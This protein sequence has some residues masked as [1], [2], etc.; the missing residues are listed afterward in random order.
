[1]NPETTAAAPRRVPIP[2]GRTV[3]G[4]DHGYPEEAPVHRRRVEAFTMDVAPVTVAQFAAFVDA[5]GHVSTAEIPPDPARHPGVD[6]SL[7][8]AGSLVF[9]PPP[10]PVPL[11]D[12]RRWWSYVP[13]TSWRCPGGPGTTALADHPVVHVSHRDASAYAR[14]AGAALPTEAQWEHAARAGGSS[15]YAWGEELEPGGVRLA[16]TWQGRF[17]WEDTDPDGYRRTSPVG[18]YPA[19]PWGLH[20]MIGNVW[21]WTD[22]PAS[23]THAGA[24]RPGPSCCAPGGSGPVVKVIKGGSHL[25]S[26]DYCRRYRPA[27]RQFEETESSTS[28]LGFRCVVPAGGE[29]SAAYDEKS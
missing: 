14:W 9:T 23:A 24:G 1:M 16:N 18:S 12:F 21:E 13:G 10:G 2:A 25:C 5:T 19:N 4:S 6:P 11:D 3:I 7:L 20:D 27:A 17:P 26:P 22:T 15:P 28:H 8:V 29:D